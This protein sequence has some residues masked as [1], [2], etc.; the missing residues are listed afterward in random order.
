MCLRSSLCL[1]FFVFS[2]S[3]VF[4]V[5]SE[6]CVFAMFL[7][8]PQVPCVCIVRTVCS[9]LVFSEFRV[10]SVFLE[11]AK[12]WVSVVLLVFLNS[13]PSYTNSPCSQKRYSH[14]QEHQ[15]LLCNF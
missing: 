15:M 1:L 13:T 10:L 12:F 9:E 2:V 3:A 8:F 14:L 11:F 7:V 4:P 6:F 5:F